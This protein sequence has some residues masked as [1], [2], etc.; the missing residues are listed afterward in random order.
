MRIVRQP[1]DFEGGPAAAG[2]GTERRAGRSGGPWIWLATCGGVGWIPV[3]PGTFGS[4][5]GLGVSW[6]LASAAIWLAELVGGAGPGIVAGIETLLA[7]IACGVGVPICTRAAAA[8]GRGSDPGM[9]VLDEAVA[10]GVVLLAVP[11][12]ERT[13]A[14][15]TAAFVLFRIFDIGKPFP[16]RRLESLPGGLGIMADDVAAAGWA[17][18]CLWIARRSIAASTLG[19]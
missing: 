3:A 11:P 14:W 12:S 9:I 5:V 7:A 15:L 8:L 4:L 13:F 19:G 1:G 6:A 17:A 18:A 10:M 2:G 16:C